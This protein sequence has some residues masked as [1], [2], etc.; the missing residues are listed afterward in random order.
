MRPELK[1][2]STFRQHVPRWST[3]ASWVLQTIQEGGSP[4]AKESTSSFR[5]RETPT[6]KIHTLFYRHLNMQI[7]WRN[8]GNCDTSRCVF[9]QTSHPEKQKKTVATLFFWLGAIPWKVACQ[10]HPS[11]QNLGNALYGTL[12][13]RFHVFQSLTGGVGTTGFRL[14]FT[15]MFM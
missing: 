4:R 13:A 6:A 5:V 3:A 11:G 7:L 10:T 1:A 12:T 8:C 15:V 9:A 14:R 2:C